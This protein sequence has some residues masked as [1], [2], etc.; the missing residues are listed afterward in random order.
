MRRTLLGLIVAVQIR[1]D[2]R[3]KLFL[4]RLIRFAVCFELRTD[5]RHVVDRAPNQAIIR[6]KAARC[7]EVCARLSKPSLCAFDIPKFTA[8][9]LL[10]HASYQ[11]HSCDAA[12]IQALGVLRFDRECLAKLPQR[13]IEIPELQLDEAAVQVARRLKCVDARTFR[14]AHERPLLLRAKDVD[15]RAIVRLLRLLQRALSVQRVTARALQLRR[16]KLLVYAPRAVM[17]VHRLDRVVA[18][19]I[20]RRLDRMLAV[21]IRLRPSRADAV[22]F[23]VYPRLSSA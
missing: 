22:A 13:V 17:R 15:K 16:R 18:S 14:G 7:K 5:R 3:K 12:T 20:L 23:A 21:P 2:C 8:L 4:L 6:R 1:N 10:H 11:R 19:A 9:L